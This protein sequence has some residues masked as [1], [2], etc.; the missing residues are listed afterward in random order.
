[1]ADE[2]L[3]CLPV[4]EVGYLG[5]TFVRSRGG[6]S[7]EVGLTRH[8]KGSKIQVIA[9]E[10]FRP[11][12]LLL[13]SANPSEQ[14]MVQDLL[15]LAGVKLPLR[16]VADR[17]YDVD[18]LRDLVAGSGSILVVPHKRRRVRP[19]RDQELVSTLY[20]E[21]WRVERFCPDLRV[22][23]NSRDGHRQPVL[24]RPTRRGNAAS[25]QRLDVCVRVLP[26]AKV[27]LVADLG[28]M[29]PGSVNDL[30]TLEGVTRGPD[31]Q[32]VTPEPILQ[33]HTI[34]G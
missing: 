24:G 23:R 11:I 21:R 17:A 12:S 30:V 4:A 28:D 18:G 26:S 27:H 3:G 31:D 7:E 1:V 6:G 34:A 8:G 15:E 9:D 16:I 20:R 13:V 19:A 25:Q 22:L 33:R 5:A 14:R 29:V 2:L 32:P 10:L